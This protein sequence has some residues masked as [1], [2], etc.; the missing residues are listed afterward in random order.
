M[1]VNGPR[2]LA[3]S[4]LLTVSSCSSD[5]TEQQRLRAE[6]ERLRAE[7]EALRVEI[8]SLKFAP[9][10][11]SRAED[12]TRLAWPP[13]VKETYIER[14]AAS[15]VSQGMQ[16]VNANPYCRCFADS[17]E[18]EFGISEYEAMMQAQPDSLGDQDDRRLYR[19]FT[20]CRSHL[21]INPN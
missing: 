18:A 8:E 11:P 15:I 4:A 10:Q 19:V 20:S 13:G 2:L 12:T 16:A 17:L 7:N 14:C 1:I 5:A 6:N 21:P 9:P 3:F